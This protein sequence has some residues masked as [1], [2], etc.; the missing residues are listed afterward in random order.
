MIYPHYTREQNLV[1]K[2]SDE[3]IINIRKDY[4]NALNSTRKLAIKYNVSQPT[5]M[6]WVSEEYRRKAIASA[7]RWKKGRKGKG[8]EYRPELLERK[9]KLQPEFLVWRYNK[10]KELQAD[11][12]KRK[13]NYSKKYRED[14][15]KYYQL[16]KNEILLKQKIYGEK[17]KEA[18]SLR[19]RKAYALKKEMSMK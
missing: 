10:N 1:C 16:H 8:Y 9:A 4:Q 18:V 6:Y 7:I 15:K 17:N 12:E 3:D 19:R 11:K 2:L 5:I 13:E 14:Q